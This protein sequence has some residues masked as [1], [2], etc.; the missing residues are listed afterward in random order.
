MDFLLVTIGSHGDVHPFVGLGI[1]LRQRGHCVRLITNEHF[2]P[3]IRAAGVEFIALGSADEYLQLA[4]NPAMWK[5]RT[6]FEAVFGAVAQS[7]ERVYDVVVENLSSD[8]IVAASSLC[9][10]ARVAQ[11][12]LDFPMA[13]VHLSPALFRTVHEPP[14][15]PGLFM[16]SWLPK[17]FKRGMWEFGDKHIVDPVI[18]PPVNALRKKVG[19]DPVKYIVRDWWHSPRCVIAMFP[20][21][22]APPQPDWPKQIRL[23]GFPL[24]DERGVAI[25]SEP[26]EEFLDFGEPPIA[27]TPGS[28]MFDGAHFFRTAVETCVRLGRRGLLLSR[29]REHLPPQL[30]RDVIHVDYAPFSLLLPRV[31]A[32]VHH[33]GI[34]TSSQAMSRGCPS[35]VTPMAHDQF[36]NGARMKRLGVAEIVPNT[37]LTPRRAARALS[38]LLDSSNVRQRCRTI[39]DKFIGADGLG[40]ACEILESLSRSTVTRDSRTAPAHSL[41][42]PANP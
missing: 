42:N 18:A 27:F 19:L 35:L 32:L 30:P 11:D 38:H 24:Y 25:L 39:A 13:S 26:L 34:G 31:A 2:A 40:R 37:R 7:L 3:L 41:P 22:F 5:P 28:A 6:G 10:A 36:D 33:G 21:W 16:P 1:R 14:K 15:L 9:L 29:H 20:D 12:K 4:N 8:T 17:W 23:A